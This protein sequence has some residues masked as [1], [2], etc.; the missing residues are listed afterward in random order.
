MT[1]HKQHLL[2]WFRRGKSIT[3]IEAINQWGDTRLA[4]TVARLKEKGHDIRTELMERTN[5]N[6]HKTRFDRYHYI[7]GPQGETVSPQSDPPAIGKR[8]NI[9]HRL[10]SAFRMG[11]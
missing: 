5:A 11:A 4:D 7:S 8:A 9:M 2:A 3:S 6:G 10:R 1:T